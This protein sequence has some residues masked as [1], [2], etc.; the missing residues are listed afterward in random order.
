VVGADIFQELLDAFEGAGKKL[1][2][3]LDA[4]FRDF[5]KLQANL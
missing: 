2:P 5:S 1:R 3:E 4:K